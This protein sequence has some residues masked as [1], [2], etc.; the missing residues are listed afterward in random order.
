[1]GGLQH[2][3]IS[4]RHCVG[5]VFCAECLRSVRPELHIETLKH[6]IR[7]ISQHV[8]WFVERYDTSVEV[9]W[10]KFHADTTI[11]ADSNRLV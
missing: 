11:A 9:D 4:Y 7:N 8:G 10:H 3:K 2:I 1:M 6:A 5:F